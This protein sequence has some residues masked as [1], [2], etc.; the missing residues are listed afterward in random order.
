MPFVYIVKCKDDTLYTGIAVDVKKRMKQHV[1]GTGAKYTKSHPV[2]ELCALWE[3]KEY[4]HAA[5]LEYKIKQLQRKEKI[6]LSENPRE[7]AGYLEN[8][9]K[10]FEEGTFENRPVF[11]IMKLGEE[12]GEKSSRKTSKP[13]DKEKN[14]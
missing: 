10:E 8:F 5:K 2:K 3:C 11:D 13:L 4:S 6:A 7:L 12:N 9:E 14:V 1:N